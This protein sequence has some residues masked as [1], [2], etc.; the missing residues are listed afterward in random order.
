[1]KL[2]EIILS[3]VKEQATAGATSSGNIASVVSTEHEDGTALIYL[4]VHTSGIAQLSRVFSKLEGVKG[5]VSVVRSNPT[6]PVPST[7]SK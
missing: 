6:S 1:M 7:R 3:R 4:T 2:H 5:V